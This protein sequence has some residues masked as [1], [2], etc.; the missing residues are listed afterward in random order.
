M[1]YSKDDYV[2]MAWKRKHAFQ[3]I[4]D[5]LGKEH[6]V[7]KMMGTLAW[8][9]HAGEHGPDFGLREAIYEMAFLDGFFEVLNLWTRDNDGKAQR[10][11]LEHYPRGYESAKPK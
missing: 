6:P 1:N 10:V 7:T 3:K 2:Y 11:M 4:A 8:G 9:R 5:E